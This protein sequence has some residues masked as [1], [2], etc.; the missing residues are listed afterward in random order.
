M[1][2]HPDYLIITSIEA[3]HLDYYRDYEDVLSAFVEY[4]EKLSNGGRIIYCADDAG[5]IAAAG[6]IA[7]RRPDIIMIKFPAHFQK[8]IFWTGVTRRVFTI[9]KA[10]P[11]MS[12]ANMK[13]LNRHLNPFC[14]PMV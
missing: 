2:F 1:N 4:G 5:A 6:M 7:E 11:V 12:K 9:A 14:G 10:L 3:D 8:T 13:K